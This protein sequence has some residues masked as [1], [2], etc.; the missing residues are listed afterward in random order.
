MAIVYKKGSLFSAPLGSILVHAVSTKSVWGSGI[1]K[2]FKTRF[3]ESFKF[4]KEICAEEGARLIGTTIFCPEENG[5]LIDNLVTSIDYGSNKDSKEDILKN[6]KIALHYLLSIEPELEL[7]IHS[8]K[9]NSGL[10]GVEWN[11]TEQVLKDVILELNYQKD[12]T[13][14]EQ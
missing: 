4:Y 9:F 10:F 12:W 5:Y 14:W 1:A 8:N 13:V 3:P 6:T 7:E 2:Q 11:L